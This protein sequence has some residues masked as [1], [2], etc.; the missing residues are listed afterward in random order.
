[1]ELAAGDPRLGTEMMHERDPATGQRFANVMALRTAKLR[2][3]VA[4]KERVRNAVLVRYE[5]AAAEPRRFVRQFARQFG[6]WRWPWLRA[7][8]TWKGGRERFTAREYEPFAPR[9]V[10]WVASQLDRDLERRFGVDVGARAAELL[11][12]VPG[13]SG[14][15]AVADSAAR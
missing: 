15:G 8:T 6:L 7:V 5:D 2:A 9:D 12:A 4:L 13:P 3:W 14:R 10:E 11:A 1:M